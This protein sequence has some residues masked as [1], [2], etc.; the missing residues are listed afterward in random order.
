M[1]KLRGEKR[2]TSLVN[3]KKKDNLA[4]YLVSSHSSEKWFRTGCSIASAINRAV[5][6][7][8]EALDDGS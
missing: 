2:R 5:R 1:S 3:E 6:V 8:G 4:I 7:E